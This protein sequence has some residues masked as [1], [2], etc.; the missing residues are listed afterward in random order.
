VAGETPLPTDE[1]LA[2]IERLDPHGIRH[3]VLADN[4]PA[5]RSAS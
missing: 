2:I 5:Q 3:S 4:P 1:Q